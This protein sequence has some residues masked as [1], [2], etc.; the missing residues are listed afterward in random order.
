MSEEKKKFDLGEFNKSFVSQMND[1][2]KNR[3]I[4][5]KKKLME[6]EKND[7]KLS[8]PINEYTIGE[9]FINI[10]NT[11]FDILDDLLQF[12][13]SLEILKNNRLFYVGMTFILFAFMMFLYDNIVQN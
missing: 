8:K 6:M 4:K 11:W 7:M 12:N 10:K 13:I 2:K 9:I 1:I 5:D 3:K